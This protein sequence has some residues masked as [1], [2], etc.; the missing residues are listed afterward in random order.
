[1]VATNWDQGP[2]SEESW[3][4]WAQ[5][6]ASPE[7]RAWEKEVIRVGACK[8]PV[9]LTGR[10]ELR[11][12]A[13]GAVLRVFDAS[14]RPGGVLILPCGNRRASR[15][16]PCSRVYQHDAFH[17]VRTGL[18][19]GKG[20]PRSVEMHPRAFVTLTAPSFGLVHRR[21]VDREGRVR[22]CNPHRSA[23]VCG[24]GVLGSCLAR[25]G[26]GDSVIGAPLCVGCYDY[27]GAVLW[28][29]RAAKLYNLWINDVRRS[30]MPQLAGLTRKAFT[31]QVKVAF[32]KVAEF[33]ER[34]QVH[35]HAVVRIDG[36]RV[37]G[38]GR[39]SGSRWRCWR[40]RFARRRR[41]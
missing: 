28:N 21:I 11:D 31:A 29:A 25:H 3:E 5:L 16:E 37:P 32:L 20:V 19:G 7:Y 10:T 23:V 12:A 22:P 34:G 6:A 2:G 17:M 30:S 24:H 36:R 40:L 39:R 33:Q 9:V 27:D 13:T 4:Q 26:E 14:S 15:C 8:N 35:F 18:A 41:G 1:M 38:T